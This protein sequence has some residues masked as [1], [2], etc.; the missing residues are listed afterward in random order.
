MLAALACT[1]RVR[2]SVLA[3]AAQWLAARWSRDS[4][5]QGGGAAIAA[6][7]PALACAPGEL[8][9]SA[10]AALQWC[11][12]ELERGFRTGRLAPLAAA[13]VYAAC[14]THALPGARLTAAEVHSAALRAQHPDGSFPGGSLAT[15]EALRALH[16]LGAATGELAC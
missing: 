4:L 12:R 11:G 13:G 2:A 5:A 9:E 10:D 1:S 14:G 16:L 15:L 3:R 6:W 8:A 7:F